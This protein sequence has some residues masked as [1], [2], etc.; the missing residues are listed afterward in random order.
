MIKALAQVTGYQQGL[1]QLSCQQQTSC[2]SCASRNK[3][4]TGIVTKALPGKV[5][6]VSV[7]SSQPL[8]VGTLVEIGLAESTVLRS[9][10]IVY[11]IPLIML[12]GGAFLAQFVF[13]QLVG[14]GEGAVIVTSFISAALGLLIA[15][16]LANKQAPNSSYQPV[17]LRVV[18]KPVSDAVVINAV[19]EDSD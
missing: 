10:F 3:C 18:G 6:H 1:L 4:G 15:R 5:N 8:P 19:S 16:R 11:M 17:L 7:A 2:G 14:A 9:A 12:L 13:T